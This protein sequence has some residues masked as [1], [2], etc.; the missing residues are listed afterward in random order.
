MDLQ[1]PCGV[2]ESESKPLTPRRPIDSGTTVGLLANDKKNAD[3]LLG[4]V[5]KRLEA[6]HG[7]REFRWLHKEAVRPAQLTPQFV[8][9]CDVVA[10]AVGD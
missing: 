1:N 2:F 4:H 3:V 5:Q 9:D 8:A 10:A 7:I 6:D